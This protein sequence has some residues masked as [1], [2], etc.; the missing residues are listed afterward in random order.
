M[1]D[2]QT[3]GW[4]QHPWVLLKCPWGPAARLQEEPRGRKVPLRNENAG[5]SD[6][7]SLP[8]PSQGSAGAR[9]AG[10]T[11]PPTPPG[12]SP[13]PACSWRNSRARCCYKHHEGWDGKP[14]QLIISYHTLF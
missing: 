4:G 8:G 11:V 3:P 10:R 7:P 2:K 6:R 14:T 1:I 12:C 9:P 5:V 13:S